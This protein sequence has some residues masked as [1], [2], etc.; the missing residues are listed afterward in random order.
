MV[1]DLLCCRGNIYSAPLVCGSA[2]S[3]EAKKPSR[4]EAAKKVAGKVFGLA[5][6]LV[7]GRNVLLVERKVSRECDGS[8]MGIG[9]RESTVNE[10]LEVESI[11]GKKKFVSVLLFTT[12]QVIPS[13]PPAQNTLDAWTVSDLE[14]GGQRLRIL[15]DRRLDYVFRTQ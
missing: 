8:G 13:R 4:A 7:D 3:T 5:Q 2:Y 12:V 6:L 11:R 1:C 9:L 10:A 14:G 15:R